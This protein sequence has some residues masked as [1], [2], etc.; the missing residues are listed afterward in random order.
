MADPGFFGYALEVVEKFLGML[1][2][3]A[4]IFEVILG[5]G[6]LIIEQ[7][8]VGVL[9]QFLHAIVEEAAAGIECGMDIGDLLKPLEKC[10]DEIRLCKRLAARDCNTAILTVIRAISEDSFRHLARGD[11]VSAVEVPRIG[12]MTA[13]AAERTALHEHDRADAGPVHRS[14]A[15]ERVDSASK[16]YITLFHGT[17][18]R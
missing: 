11:L 16:L 6:I 10:S 7:D 1:K 8:E 4:G 18:S 2:R 15:L 5:I 14:K 9:E 12:V 17:F 13:R 3:A